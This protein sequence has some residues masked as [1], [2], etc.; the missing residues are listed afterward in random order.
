MRGGLKNRAYLPQ[1]QIWKKST[2]F[3]KQVTSSIFM[4]SQNRFCLIQKH[5]IRFANCVLHSLV[6]DLLLEFNA[7]KARISF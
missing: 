4:Q 3:P 6:S 2:P 5:E 7:I 1:A